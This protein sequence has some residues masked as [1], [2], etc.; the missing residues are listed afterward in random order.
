MGLVKVVS[1]FARPDAWLRLQ[2]LPDNMTKTVRSLQQNIEKTGGAGAD[3]HKFH[4]LGGIVADSIA[5]EEG[6]KDEKK[7]DKKDDKAAASNNNKQQPQGQDKSTPGAALKA[8]RE[9]K[10]VPRTV[11]NLR[12][13]PALERDETS[14]N[15]V[16]SRED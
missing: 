12:Q 9:S 3:G 10:L 7:D 15:L 16:G 14:D 6:N 5:Q 8:A 2:R 4:F 11:Q 13:Q 1:Y